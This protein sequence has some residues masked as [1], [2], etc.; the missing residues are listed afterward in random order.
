MDR[1]AG[2]PLLR[3][4][5]LRTYFELGA[6]T[7]RAVDGVSFALHPGRVLGIVG[8]SGS[9]KSATALSI[10]RLIDPPGR[11]VGGRVLYR[12]QDLMRLPEREMEALRGN[13]I[14]MVFQNPMTSLDP[15]FRIGQ[16]IAETL[17]THERLSAAE[18]RRRT[19]ELL[20]LV[21][22][23]D[24][25]RRYDDYP[26]QFSGGMRQR[27]L[28]AAA[29]ACKPDVLIADEPTTAL[30]VTIQAQILR[31]LADLQRRLGSAMVLITHD[32][33]VIAA[34]ADE[35]LVMY[36]GRVVE[37]ADVDTIF[38]A[39][40]HPYTRGLL[41]SLV[42]L[43]DGRDSVLQP[44][45]GAPPNLIDLPPGCPFRP[46]CIHA[47][48]RCATELPPLRKLVDGRQVACHLAVAS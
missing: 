6:G 28:I 11:I 25:E 30:D 35:V 21:G 26:H 23:P 2:A 36:A 38:H 37:L 16:Q 34:M 22:I 27:V 24:G 45:A 15:S 44:I 18:A 5:D 10:M 29:I 20:R 4:E 48:E 17:V 31:L 43:E 7:L 41:Q 14:G 40:K 46:R 33:G 1:A 39:P 47:V 3:V 13:R 8:E 9:G 12:E 19:I 32:L 42:R